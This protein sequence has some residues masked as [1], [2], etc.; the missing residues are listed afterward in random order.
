MAKQADYERINRL[1]VTPIS[2]TWATKVPEGMVE[3]YVEDLAGFSDDILRAAF[4]EVRRSCKTLPRIA[5]F[6][7]ACRNLG[8]S[9][10][11]VTDSAEEYYRSLRGRDFDA[12]GAAKRFTEQFELT[13][14][15]R[16]AKAEGWDS[17]LMAYAF[18]A[19]LL[20]SRYQNR[21]PNPGF[22][23]AVL[24]GSRSLTTEEVERRCRDFVA[25]C[26]RQAAT[27]TIEVNPPGYLTDEW[28]Q[29]AA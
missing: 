10:G 20:Q 3:A 4:L 26:K 2:T 6:V 12:M 24:T 16:R 25:S 21:S 13:E 29:K 17:P 23:Q 1:I 27:G 15:A 5:H 28:R 9:R 11:G 18:E 19:A 14:Q 8:G 7:E 22:N